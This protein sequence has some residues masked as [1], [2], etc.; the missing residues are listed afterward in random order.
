MRAA[1]DKRRRAG[2][3]IPMGFVAR[4]P[5]CLTRLRL[6]R[7]SP[8]HG[9]N[10]YERADD[11]RVGNVDQ[12]GPHHRNEDERLRRASVARANRLQI[13][14]RRRGCAQ[15]ESA[16]ARDEHRRFIVSAHH[17]KRN[18]GRVYRDPDRLQREYQEH[19]QR[20]CGKLPEAQAH[21]RHR[22]E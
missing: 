16:L 18:E 19:R 22:E 12:E 7:R 8:Q 15:P 10:R 6:A 5:V 21:Q 14:D 9:H 2:Y 4:L 11:D 20:K 3:L 17:A 13:S 1:R